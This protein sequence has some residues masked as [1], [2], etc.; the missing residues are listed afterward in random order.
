MTGGTIKKI[1]IILYILLERVEMANGK[2]T[3]ERLNYSK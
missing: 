2:S 1:K 3:E